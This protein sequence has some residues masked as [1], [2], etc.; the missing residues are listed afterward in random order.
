MKLSVQNLT[1]TSCKYFY[2]Y[3]TISS[4]SKSLLGLYSF[5][6]KSEAVFHK[7]LKH[8]LKIV[9]VPGLTYS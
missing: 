6:Q 4:I 7:Y 2:R 9:Y 5:I 8:S 3:L 1:V